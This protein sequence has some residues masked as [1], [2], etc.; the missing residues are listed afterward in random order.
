M[1]QSR[2]SESPHA[3]RL[4]PTVGRELFLQGSR[5]AVP[6]RTRRRPS[7]L[8]LSPPRRR[9]GPRRASD[10]RNAEFG[11]KGDA[12]GRPP[13]GMIQRARLRLRGE[14]RVNSGHPLGCHP[15]GCQTVADSARPSR[16]AVGSAEPCT[17]GHR[18]AEQSLP[19]EG[20][21]R[22]ATLC[23]HRPSGT[24]CAMNAKGNVAALSLK[25]LPS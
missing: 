5:R 20:M 1:R 25:E 8:L 19:P 15:E 18:P 9:L 6:A 7:R 3:S 11:R 23:G 4:S 2:R 10:E 22:T 13:S 24:D 17:A 12:S 16:F 21:T 14:W